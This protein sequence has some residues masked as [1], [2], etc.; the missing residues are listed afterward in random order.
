MRVHFTKDIIIRM[1]FTKETVIRMHLTKN[2]IMRVHF[3]KGH[4]NEDGGRV[5][6]VRVT[7]SV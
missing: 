6:V 2:T 4:Y 5:V 3:S 1:H 7:T